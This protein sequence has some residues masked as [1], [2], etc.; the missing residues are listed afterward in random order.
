VQLHLQL[1]SK[2]GHQVTSGHIA[3]VFGRFVRGRTLALCQTV[4]AV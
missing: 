1:L 4:S 2:Q 3:P